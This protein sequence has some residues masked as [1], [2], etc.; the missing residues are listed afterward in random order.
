MNKKII[1]AFSF[2]LCFSCPTIAQGDL[3]VFPKRITFDG[4]KKK[5]ETVN[6]SN[7]GKDTATYTLSYSEIRM[8]KDG[9]FN[10]TEIPEDGQNFASPYLRYYPRTIT[11]APNESQNIKI[12][13]IKT[14]EL[15]QGEY[16]S[17]LYFRAV[18]KSS[19]LQQ[20][21]I[22][23]TDHKV[24]ELHFNLVPVFG[25]SIANIITIGESSTTVQLTN[26]R[27]NES[28]DGHT[29]TLSLD[30]N[31]QGNRSA[32]GTI[33]VNHISLEGTRQKV[34]TIKGF[35]IYSPGNLR[36][37]KIELDKSQNIDYSKGKLEVHFTTISENT[38]YAE[39]TLDLNQASIVN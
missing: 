25:L 36:K 24:K 11:L 3:V 21:A 26:L 14:S 1:L 5:V 28:K 6:L 31:R 35:A 23:T 30:F 37:S 2:L 4:I 15:K 29:T 22:D 34:A 8:G 7:V 12:Q 9:S 10:V 39:A 17:H 38:L 32:Y 20:E 27:I 33:E 13:L 19:P 16:R 18:P